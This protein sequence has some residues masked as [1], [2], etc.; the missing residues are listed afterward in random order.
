[1]DLDLVKVVYELAAA[2]LSI[3]G[4][5]LVAAV[6]EQLKGDEP[7]RLLREF[8]VEIG[9][10]WPG[11]ETGAEA[12]LERFARLLLESEALGALREF[13]VTGDAR[14]LSELKRLVADELDDDGLEVSAEEAAD[15]TATCL[16][17]VLGRAQR[18]PQAATDVVAEQG[19]DQVRALGEQIER[20]QEDIAGAVEEG[21]YTGER[22]LSEVEGVAQR[23]D[24]VGAELRQHLER[25]AGGRWLSAEW[26][27]ADTV[28]AV[29]RLND[30]APELITH[31]HEHAGDPLDPQ[32]AIGL[33]GHTPAW[34]R[35]AP[36]AYDQLLAR[37]AESEGRWSEAIPAWVAAAEKR[38]DPALGADDYARAAVTAG[39]AGEMTRR[40]ELLDRARDL[41]PDSPRLQLEELDEDLPA[42]ELIGKLEPLESDD[43]ELSALIAA[44]RALAYLRVPDLRAAE[45][46]LVQARRLAPESVATVVTE[47]NLAVQQGRIDLYEGHP[48]NGPALA[49]ARTTVLAMREKLTGKGRHEEAAR[50]LMLAVDA[51][52]VGGD[53]KGALELFERATEGDLNAPTGAEVLADAA[54][55]CGDD[56]LALKLVVGAPDT[57]GVERIRASAELFT[58]SSEVV[59]AAAERL[60]E[61][62]A[63]RDNPEG[64]HAALNRLVVCIIHGGV[65]WS[66]TAADRLRE[67]G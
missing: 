17:R 31:L 21:N 35:E 22:I 53:R 37:I 9:A 27:P 25:P 43:D 34:A 1:M 3:S 58:G 49:S 12:F 7:T 32:A 48:L 41:D 60:D 28:K 64:D 61:I 66:E 33:I 26:A 24:E 36:P 38:E 57:P 51:T 59:L 2:G 30:E 55:R 62:A 10:K 47:A 54:A 16:P 20:S 63:D 46:Q 23:I 67:D 5:Q 44:Q 45:A 4:E 19:R 40:A 6:R 18:T 13:A 50:L 15:L 52:A 65:P 39:V 11:T 29:G 56:R 8:Q 42:K 14:S